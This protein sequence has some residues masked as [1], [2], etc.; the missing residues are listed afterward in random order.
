MNE[1]EACEFMSFIDE[2]VSHSSG[3]DH[4]AENIRSPLNFFSR[5]RAAL[6]AMLLPSNETKS[7]FSATRNIQ[8]RCCANVF[9]YLSADDHLSTRERAKIMRE[10]FLSAM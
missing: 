6:F 3:S 9:V 5:S 4:A 2:P 7:L 10:E 8:Q 1:P